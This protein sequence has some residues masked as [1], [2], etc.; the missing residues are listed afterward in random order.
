[1]AEKI[2]EVDAAIREYLNNNKF[3][4]DSSWSRV[5]ITQLFRVDV[6]NW[7]D[8]ENFILEY[9]TDIGA[10]DNNTAWFRYK[11]SSDSRYRPTGWN[12]SRRTYTIMYVMSSSALLE[13]NF[14]CD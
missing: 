9:A 14:D 12:S 2:F 13:I 1:M 8:V 5:A 6:V 4:T 7:I 11:T 10:Y 3:L